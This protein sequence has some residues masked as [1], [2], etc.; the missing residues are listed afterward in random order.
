MRKTRYYIIILLYYTATGLLVT[1]NI[2]FCGKD[3][4]LYRVVDIECNNI[5]S[6]VS[7]KR[8]IY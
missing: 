4:S 2:G 8:A 5:V 1:S 6:V 3:G 7:Y